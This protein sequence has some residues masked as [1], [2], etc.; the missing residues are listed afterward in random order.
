MAPALVQALCAGAALGATT[1]LSVGPNNL[2]MFREGLQHGRVGRIAFAV[3]ASYSLL[4]AGATMATTAL[5]AHD[6]ASPIRMALILSGVLLLTSL[7][8]FSFFSAYR[9]KPATEDSGPG[10]G[11]RFLVVIWIN[12]LTYLEMFFA[13][14]VVAQAYSVEQRAAFFGGLLLMATICC[15][16]Y[17]GLGRLAGRSS[18]ARQNTRLLDLASGLILVGAAC[19]TARPLLA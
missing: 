7:A 9:P 10:D 13:P 6:T 14:A 17:P 1:I 8:A 19:L 4:L 5:P 18:I 16:L 12:P 3:W 11:L 15:A 2:M